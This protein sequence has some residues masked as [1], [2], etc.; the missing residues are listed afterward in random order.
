MEKYRLEILGV[1]ETKMKGNG[2]R[3]VGKGRCIFAGIEKGRAK[4][5]V[6]IFMLERVSQ[7][8]REWKCVSKRIVKIRLRIE[9]VWVSV[10]QVY[11]PTEDSKNEVKDSFY[12]QLEGTV[13]GVPK[14]VKLVVL[15]DLNARVG[16][17]VTVWG[18]VIGKHG[19]AVE[20]ENGMRLLQFCAEN[21]LG[22]TKSWFQHKEIHKFTWECRGRNQRSIIDFC[23]VRGTMKSQL[24][25]VKVVR[26]AEVGS[27]HYLL[28]MII[29]LKMDGKKPSKSRTGSCNTRVR[30][31]RNKEVRCKFEA[32]LRNRYR[33]N[34]KPVEDDVEAA[35]MELK[36]GILRSA[37]EVCG[38]SI[39]DQ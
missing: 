6:A 18:D 21:D 27:D 23:L 9:G 31:L 35:W 4:A 29:K 24:R 16:R 1:S 17:N 12:E 34:R 28:L 14:Q 39:K 3:A 2:S 7:Y 26:G 10:I 11:A 25:D 32:R 30:K 20:N 22:I 37:V 5:G 38:V 8:L 15:G 13:R 33:V 36:E 19:E